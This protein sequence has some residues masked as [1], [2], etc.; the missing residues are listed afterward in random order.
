MLN[1]FAGRGLISICLIVTFTAGGGCRS[2]ALEASGGMPAQQI[3]GPPVANADYDAR[4]PRTCAK[5][6]TRPD[7]ATATALVQCSAE[8]FANYEVWLVTDVKV[9]MG[10]PR[11]V[12]TLLDSNINDLDV[13]QMIYPLRGSAVQYVCSLVKDYGVGTNCQRWPAAPDRA[14]RCWHTLFGE[15]KCSMAVGSGMFDVKLQAGPTTY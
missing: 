9:E 14:G 12:N 4:N 8:R 13:N 3:S 10:T 2:S 1:R 15:W 7:V 11:A 5:V 6:T